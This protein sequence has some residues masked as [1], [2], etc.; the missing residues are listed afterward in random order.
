M[1]FDKVRYDSD[2]EYRQRLLAANRARR[3]ENWSDPEYR[4]RVRALN[5]AAQARRRKKVKARKAKRAWHNERYA[6]DPAFREAHKA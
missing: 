5:R 6:N 2:P 4:E 3:E 1:P